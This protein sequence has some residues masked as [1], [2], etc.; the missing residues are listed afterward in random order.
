[1]L[2]LIDA[3]LI[4]YEAA[5][6]ADMVDEGYERRSFDYVID[7]ID[8][9]IKFIT[10]NSGCDSYELFITGKD[11]FRYDIATVKPYKGNRS[12]KPKPF[13]LESTRKLLESYGA[14][15]CDGMEADDMLAVRAREMEYKD[16]CICS[17]DK[18]LRMVPCMQY[19]WE[20][21]LQPEWGPELVD[22]LGELH[23]RF[24]DKILKNGEKSNAIKKVWG[25]GLK[26]FYAQLIIGDATDNISGLEGKGGGLVHQ[27]IHP[28]TSEE[29]L[30]TAAFSA[31]TD[32]YGDT[33]AERLLE[34]GRLLW[35]HD[36]LDEEGKVILWELP[37]ETT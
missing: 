24:S 36:T 13:Y 22:T 28:C 29:E 12:D 32:K 6:A 33:A 34:Q 21:G 35:M 16:C 9:S 26:W 25:T 15:V 23:F 5:S 4:A 30:F 10:E 7:K 31:Y 2:A 19:S 14:V 27:I 8:E 18:D 37:Y 3:D 20:V 17:R 1:M 11:N